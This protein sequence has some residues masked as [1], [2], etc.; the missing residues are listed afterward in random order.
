MNYSELHKDRLARLEK[1]A[2]SMDTKWKLPVLNIGVGWD[3]VIGLIPGIGDTATACISAYIVREAHILG[4]PLLTK[5]HMVWNIIVDWFVGLI[6]FL[7]DILD[8]GW[9]ANRKNVDLIQKHVAKKIN[10]DHSDHMFQHS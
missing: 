6:P 7:G 2:R 3:T 1:L 9:K 4:V 5:I 10:T 8:I